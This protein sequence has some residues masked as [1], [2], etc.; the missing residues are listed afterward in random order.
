LEEEGHEKDAAAA[1][2]QYYD[3]SLVINVM[4]TQ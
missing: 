1:G 2:I 3:F 4:S